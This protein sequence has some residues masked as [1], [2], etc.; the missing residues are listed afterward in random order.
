[1][2]S[3]YHSKVKLVATGFVLFL[4]LIALT[5]CKGNKA[6]IL[7]KWKGSGMVFN[8]ELNETIKEVDEKYQ[9]CGRCG[10]YQ[11]MEDSLQKIMDEER[12]IYTDNT[13]QFADDGNITIN[14]EGKE[15]KGTW[16]MEEG[17][18]YTYVVI[19][20]AYQK[21]S[22]RWFLYKGTGSSP[23]TGDNN[24]LDF[25]LT[26]GGQLDRENGDFVSMHMKKAE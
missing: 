23:F 14:R 24:E 3:K 11:V 22:E 19:N 16:K 20:S 9:A 18:E 12:K 10:M 15:I 2:K 25:D 6:K 26:S 7:G 21:L 5:S 17:T 1:M 4:G 8:H 13:Y